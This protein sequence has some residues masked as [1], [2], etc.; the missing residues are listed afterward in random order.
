MGL[1]DKKFATSVQFFSLKVTP[2][3]VSPLNVHGALSALFSPVKK[4]LEQKNSSRI[5]STW[6]QFA[7]DRVI[8]T[9]IVCGLSTC[10]VLSNAINVWSRDCRHHCQKSLRTSAH[11]RGIRTA[12]LRQFLVSSGAVGTA[13]SLMFHDL[14][15]LQNAALRQ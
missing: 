8:I 15:I 9:V 14:A 2:P 12:A 7:A 4:C 10:Q 5:K 1:H 6:L 13:A 11:I 3:K